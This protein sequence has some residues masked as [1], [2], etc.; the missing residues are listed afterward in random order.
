MTYVE[1]LLKESARS[2]PRLHLSR[3]CSALNLASDFFGSQCFIQLNSELKLQVEWGDD[4][5]LLIGLPLSSEPIKC[6]ETAKLL[7]QRNA[8][9]EGLNWHATE[10]A[11]IV[12]CALRPVSLSLNKF[13]ETILSLVQ[14]RDEAFKI[15]EVEEACLL[16]AE[17]IVEVEISGCENAHCD[18]EQPVPLQNET[19]AG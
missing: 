17:E 11:G 2:T 5:L 19:S 1:K 12:I 9:L 6:P 14:E 18:G 15:P 8:A 7:T 10:D 4:D 13:R 3:L 16:F